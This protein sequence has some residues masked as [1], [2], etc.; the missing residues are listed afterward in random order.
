[1]TVG[2]KGQKEGGARKKES[3]TGSLQIPHA[4]PIVDQV[5]VDELRMVMHAA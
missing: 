4:T 3:I 5:P 1:M 2:P